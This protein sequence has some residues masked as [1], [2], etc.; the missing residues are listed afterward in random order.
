MRLTS[1]ERVCVRTAAVLMLLL[2]LTVGLSFLDLGR[3]GFVAA[4]AVAAAKALLV[5]YVFMELGRGVD[6]VRL[7]ASAGL[8][9]FALLLAG[10]LADLATRG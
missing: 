2:A 5:A 3:F 8:V 7:A 6:A 4:L 1:E 10:A 9:W